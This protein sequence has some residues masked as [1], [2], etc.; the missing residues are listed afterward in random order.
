VKVSSKCSLRLRTMWSI[1]L[2]S[3]ALLP[4]AAAKPLL[5]KRWADH[6]LKHSWHA[7]PQGWKS[8]GPAPA[9]H[10]L[11]MRIALTQDK[12]DDLVTALYE[13]SDPQHDRCVQLPLTCE[14]M[15]LN[16][17]TSQDM[18]NILPKSR[19]MHLSHLT[20]PPCSW[21]TNGLRLMM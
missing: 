5:N 21:S 8:H 15:T 10:L 14:E 11:D 13:V 4:L 9:N 17:C 19:S 1:F 12:F 20:H 7:V 3:A 2:L 6:E 16:D 18:V